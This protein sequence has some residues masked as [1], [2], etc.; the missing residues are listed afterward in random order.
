MS[1]LMLVS[2]NSIHLWNYYNLIRDYF[3]EVTI[4]T[5][6]SSNKAKIDGCNIYE[7]E[8]SLKWKETIKGVLKLIP[9]IKKINPDIIH[10][11]QMNV[12]TFLPILA[13]KLGRKKKIPIIATA[14][15]SD[16]L[17]TPYKKPF[18]MWMLKYILKNVNAITADSFFLASKIKDIYLSDKKIK[19]KNETGSS[20]FYRV[21]VYKDKKVNTD[22]TSHYGI[23]DIE[24]Q[25]ANFGIDISYNN[26]I[27]AQV[28]DFRE[29]NKENIIYSNR[30]HGA[31]YR[32]EKVI[33]GFSNFIKT[34]EQDWELVIAGDGKLTESY[35][36]LVKKLN[37]ES[38]VVF[39]G[40]LN[41]S[42]NYMYYKKARIYVSIPESDATSISLLEAMYSGCIPVV[43]RLPANMEWIL[44]KINGILV[45]DVTKLHLYL[46]ES[47]QVNIEILQWI[48]RKMVL[49]KGSKESNKEKFFEVYEKLLKKSN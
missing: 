25:I 39:T 46:T 21:Q 43:S 48:N 27:D 35:K 2:L 24:I 8:F 5:N 3:D 16:V 12:F 42:D 9:I 18:N 17:L 33:E 40:W 31:V 4:I 22:N 1:K 30:L 19:L 7:I 29:V 41:Q 15:G 13:K 47:L 45:D 34:S 37:I 36:Y 20:L 23:K 10:C 28:K 49:M 38:K 14:W 32:I 6:I 44:D 26:N 11:H